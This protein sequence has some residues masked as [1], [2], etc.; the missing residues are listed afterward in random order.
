[1]GDVEGSRWED[2][3]DA[4]VS[5]EMLGSLRSMGGF[6]CWEDG[7]KFDFGP[8][9]WKNARLVFVWGIGDE[10]G[11]IGDVMLDCSLMS[12]SGFLI[13]RPCVTCA[14][15]CV[16]NPPA[17]HFPGGLSAPIGHF[18][19]RPNA[20]SSS[21]PPRGGGAWMNIIRRR[22]TLPRFA[23]G[24]VLWRRF[25]AP[26]MSSALSTDERTEETSDAL[27]RSRGCEVLYSFNIFPN[28]T[29]SKMLSSLLFPQA[30]WRGNY[31]RITSPPFKSN[32]D[33]RESK[34]KQPTCGAPPV[35]RGAPRAPRR[36]SFFSIPQVFRLKVDAELTKLKEAFVQLQDSSQK[37]DM[38]ARFEVLLEDRDQI[39]ALLE[40][41]EEERERMKADLD[42]ITGELE[43]R[44]LEKKGFIKAL[45]Q[46]V[47]KNK[48]LSASLAAAKEQK[49]QLV[50]KV[51]GY[52]FRFCGLVG[53]TD[54]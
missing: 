42:V 44:E 9:F 45:E 52:V 15:L 20:Q 38:Q 7:N 36:G 50:S 21:I 6:C 16:P 17:R 19:K 30:S 26:I 29:L 31:I 12:L 33:A 43:D 11:K 13:A 27:V 35:G 1:M 54:T 32:H 14:S 25:V 40:K 37:Q 28:C 10:T 48:A 46:T 51:G 34:P 39:H 3:R 8:A 53:Y 23:D 47:E 2:G 18:R 4:G 5:W 24:D 41:G 49:E 22:A